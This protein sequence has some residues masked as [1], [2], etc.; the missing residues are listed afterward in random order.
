MK[1]TTIALE[2]KYSKYL[3]NKKFFINTADITEIIL[4]SIATTATSIAVA[5]TVIGLPYSVAAASV[6]ATVFGCL[7]ETFS[8]KIKKKIIYYSQLY[9]LTN[10][11][12]DKNERYIKSKKH[13]GI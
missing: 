5:F 4:K 6:K 11:F 3:M 2:L 9:T 13:S 12:S 10:E 1:I 8:L 7:S